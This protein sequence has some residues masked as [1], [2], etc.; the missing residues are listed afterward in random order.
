MGAGGRIKI[1]MKTAKVSEMKLLNPRKCMAV[2]HISRNSRNRV[3]ICNG[4][5][6]GV[7]CNY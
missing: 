2:N 6:E 7:G 5:N 3:M 4:E 1:N